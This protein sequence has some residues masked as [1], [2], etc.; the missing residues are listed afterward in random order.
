MSLR[1]P[2]PNREQAQ[3]DKFRDLTHALSSGENHQ[4]FKG[5]AAEDCDA[6]GGAPGET[7]LDHARSPLAVSW[8]L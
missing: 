2:K 3:V 5:G 8:T 4:A 1:A 7:G 6:P